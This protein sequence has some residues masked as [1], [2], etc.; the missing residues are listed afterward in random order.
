MRILFRFAV[1]RNGNGTWG[2]NMFR[3]IRRY[4]SNNSWNFVNRE[5][6]GFIHQEADN[7]Y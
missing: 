6:S 4:N 1:S 5:V 3:N 2:L 7:W